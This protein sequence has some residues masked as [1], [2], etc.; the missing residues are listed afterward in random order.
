MFDKFGVP[1]PKDGMTWDD[2]YDLNVKMTRNFDGT[3]YYGIG[4]SYNHQVLLN[5]LSIPIVDG[6]SMKVT[7]DTDPRWNAWVQNLVRFYQSPGNDLLKANQLNEPNE[8]N[9]FFKDRTVAMFMAL[10]ALHTEKEINDMNWDIAPFPS[11][12]DSPGVGPQ[13]YP[14]F[15]YVTSMSDHKDDA[16]QAIAYLTTDEYQLQR[17]KEGKFLSVLSNKS[18]RQAFGQDNSLY[19]G[20]HITALQPEQYAPASE[21]NKYSSTVN[22]DLGAAMK[23]II[24]SGKDINTA[25]RETAEKSNKKIADAEAAAGAK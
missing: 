11:F 17:S 9:R 21:F 12:K 1:Y 20:K 10:T 3:Q 16:F 15:F 18:I 14:C 24:L 23:D 19:K 13:A 25:L 2:L 7:Y 22:G 4:A 6:A 5:Q 8:R